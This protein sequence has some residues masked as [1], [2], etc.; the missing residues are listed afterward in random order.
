V[1]A[2]AERR[3]GLSWGADYGIGCSNRAYAMSNHM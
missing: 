1:H 2:K 3:R